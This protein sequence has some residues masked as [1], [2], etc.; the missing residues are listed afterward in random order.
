MVLAAVGDVDIVVVEDLA[1]GEDN[2]ERFPCVVD[3]SGVEIFGDDGMGAN[4]GDREGRSGR[5]GIGAKEIV[6]DVSALRLACGEI[7]T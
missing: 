6:G 1:A 7:F 5:E 3:G 4:V 2:A